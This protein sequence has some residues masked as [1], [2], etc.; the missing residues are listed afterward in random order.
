MYCKVK[1]EKYDP[2]EINE[3][4]LGAN[5][6]VFLQSRYSREWGLH[7]TYIP[8]IVLCDTSLLKE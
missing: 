8:T 2:A 5:K 7:F 3:G 4:A 1:R 6:S